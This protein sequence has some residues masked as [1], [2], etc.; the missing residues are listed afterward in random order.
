MAPGPNLNPPSASTAYT[1]SLQLDLSSSPLS[2]ESCQI[3]YDMLPE[4]RPVAHKEYKGVRRTE[5]CLAQG[6]THQVLLH[7]TN[8]K[9][10]GT[11]AGP[12]VGPAV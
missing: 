6:T 9:A 5:G 11:L 4:V 10:Q 3:S 2:T 8:C 12:C 1:H 7:C